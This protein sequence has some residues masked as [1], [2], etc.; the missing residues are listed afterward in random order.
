MKGACSFLGFGLLLVA[1]SASAA[2]P[3]VKECISANEDGQDLR[4]SA[5]LRNAA[6]RFAL[7]SNASCPSPLREDCVARLQ[8]TLGAI[9]TIVFAA[10]DSA[11]SAVRGVTIVMDGSPLTGAREEIPFDVEPG[12][13]TF[14]LAARGYLPIRKNFAIDEGVKGRAELVVFESPKSAATSSPRQRT[15]A[16]IV[17][18]VGIVAVGVGAV[19]GL[20]AKTT[21]DGA[22]S[23]CG[24]PTA[25]T[26]VCDAT[27]LA[28]GARADRQGAIST[29]GFV[30]GTAL[31]AG[32]ILLFMT[33]PKDRSVS[34]DASGA[35]LRLRG[36][37]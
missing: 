23:N 31:I 30:A 7:C 13:H 8:A 4:R 10:K 2:D 9:P 26:R 34:V 32:G 17:G 21:Y 24:S 25:G 5:K 1:S 15:V 37:W 33:S 20:L 12:E 29:I 11:G 22:V 35:G 28:E 27:G 18:G 16:Y 6:D 14:E 36:S 19:F 3:T